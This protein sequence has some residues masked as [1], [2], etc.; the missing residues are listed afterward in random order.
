MNLDNHHCKFD[1]P[2]RPP[3]RHRPHIIIPVMLVAG[4]IGGA[5]VIGVMAA[6]Y[7]GIGHIFG[8]PWN[9]G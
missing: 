8:L 7:V 2:K 6:M 4:V 1:H 5:V 9:V 3:W